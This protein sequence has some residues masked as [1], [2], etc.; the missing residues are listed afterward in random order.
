MPDKIDKLYEALKA[1]GAVSKSREN[2]RSYMLASGEQGYRNRKQLYDAL[3]ADG[4]VSSRNYEEFRDRLGL[5]AVKPQQPVAKPSST[6]QSVQQPQKPQPKPQKVKQQPKKAAWKPTWQ[7]KMGMQMQLDETMRQ[8]KQS[9]QNFNTRMEN[10][11]KGNTLGK[12]S[13]VK[14]NP[15]SGKMERRYY[16][17]HGDEV[18]TPL[19]QS[20][21]NL[22][23]RD[24]WEA[25]TEEGRRHREKRIQNDFE[26][27]VGASIDKYDP[28]N[29]AAMVW[30]QAEDKSNE[31]FGRYLDERSK[32]SWSNFLRGAADGM[33]VTGGLGAD[34]VDTGIKAFATHLKYHDLQRM[35]DDA[36]NMLGKKKQQSIIEDMYGALKNRYPQATEQQL[37]QAATEMAREQSDRRMYELA[38]AKNA[39][40]DAAEYFIRKVAAGNAMGTL[41][42]AAARAQAGTTGDREAR[43]DAE[44][45]FEKKGHKVAGIAGTVTGFALDPLTWASAGAGG[46]AVKGTTWLGDKMIGEAAMRKF[47]TT[48]G[49]RMLGGAIGGAVNFGTYEA[50]S[51]ALDQMKWG[52][53]IDKE[54]GERKDGF[55][56]GNVAGRAGHGLMM[57]AVTG[58]IA[59][60]LGNVSDKLVRATESTVGK[61]GIRAGELGVGTVAEGTIFA[62]PEI[63]DTYGQYGDLINSLS[64]ESSP[65]Y[66]ADEQERAAKIEELRNS[67]GDALMDVW[68][69]NMAMIA[70]FKAQH[71]LKSA[72]R[73]IYDLAR[74]K[75]GKVG[76]ETRLRSILDGRGDLALTEDEKKELERRGYGDLKDLTEEY[77]RY[78][79]AKEEYDKARP[80]TTDA[81]RMI[82]GG[83]GQAEL[84]YN[85]FVELMTDNSVSEAARAKMYYYL[86]GHG[87]PMSTVMGSSILEDKDADGN[88]TGYTVQSFGANGVI[89]SRSFGDKKRAD[90]EA[91]RIN[92]Q[93]ELNGFDVGERYYD[94]Q[95]DNKRMYEA[96][97]SVAEETG[98]PA[99]LLFDLMKRKTEAMNEVELEWAEKILNAY[100]GL[101][102]KY[103]SSEV[104]AA[105]NEE[106]GIDVDKAI[107]KERNRRSE[108][109]QKA[110]DEYANR[111]FADVKRKQEEAAERGEA[112][113]D[114]DATTSN[115][116][117]AALLGI[118]DGEQ[119]DPVSAAFNRGHEADAQERQD[120]AIELAD[121]NNAEAQ[122]AWNGVVQRINEDAAY[123]VAQQR[124]QTKQMQHTDGS[125]RPAILK[126]KDSEGND[127]QVYIVDGNVQMMPDGSMVDKAS[128]D[129]IVVV[130]NPATGERKQID[131]SADTGISSLGEVTTAEQREADIERSRQEYVQAQIDEA[132]GTVR[133]VPGQQ[134]VLPTGE[135]AVVV[136][137]DADGENITVA[138]GD[139]TQATVQ[140]SELQ[141]IRDEKAAA[142]YRQRHGI[143]E[144]P[145]TQQ[146]EASTPA[147]PQADG[148]VAGAPADYTADM[149]L[150]IRD[151]DGSEKPAMVM[152]RV[153][154][155]NGSFVPDANGN[156]IEYFMDG[157]VKHDHE[158]KLVDKVVSHVA[159]Q[160]PEAAPVQEASAETPATVE[161]TPP[162]VEQ[163]AEVAQQPVQEPVQTVEPQPAQPAEAPAQ[164]TE[165][166]TAEP[167]PI[168]EDGEEDW[169]ATTPERA[170]AYI[171][172]EAGLSRSEGNEF[173][174]AQTQAAQSALVK[175]KSAQMPRVGTSIKKY[176]E[177]KAKRQEK[178]DEA[179]RVLDYWQQ[180]RNI[181]NDIQRVENER[182]AAE[183][184]VRHDEA[185]A[186]AQAEYEARKQAEAERKAVGNENPMP[187]ITEK[188]NN[189][190]KVDGHRD[191]IMLP[192]GT[193]LKGHYVLHESGA[194]SPSHNPE[195]WQKTDGFPMDANDNSVNDRDYERDHDAQEHTQSIAR[196]YDQRALQS[197]PVVSNDGVVLSGNGRTMAGELAARDNTD[198]AYVN[199]LKEYAPKFGFTAEQ[200]GAMQH[201]RVSFVPDEAMPYTAETFAKFNQQE[202]KSQNKTEQAVK[203]GKT[204]SDDSFKG[205]VRTINSYDTLGDF[206]S[207]A[208]AS[209]GA[210]YDLHSA[211]VVPQAQLA[212]MVDGVRG[213]EKLSAVGREFLENMLIGKAFESDPEVVRMLTAEPAMRQ[214][215]ITALGEI[216]DNIALGGD[217]SLQGELADAVKLCFDARQGGA[218]YGEIVSTY[219]RQGVLFADPDELQTVADF[220]NATMLMLADVLNDKRV[221]LLKTTLQ[222]YNNNARQSASGQTD[223]FAGGIQSREDILR[224]VITFINENYGKRKEIEAARAEAVE[225]RKA[226]SVQQDGTPPAVST[227]GEATAEP[228]AEP[229]PVEAEPVE[230]TEPVGAEPNAVQ[231]AL[232]AAEQETNT[233]PT[234]AQKEAGNYKKGHVKIDGYDVTIE[235]PKGSVRRGIDAS[236]KQWEQEMQNTYGY[237]RGTEGVDGDHIDVFFSEDPSQGDV[238]VVDQVNKDGSFDEHKVMYGFPD[239]ESA[240]KAYLSN[241]EDGWQGLGAITP[242]SKEEFKKWIDSSHRK[243]KPFA[244]YSSVKPLGDTQ[245]GE[246]PTA[247]YSIEPTTY[248]NKKGKTTPMHLVTFGRELSKDEIRAGKELAKESRGWW[249]RE[250]SGFMMRDEDSAKALAEALSN[251]EA[252]QDA[253]PLS[254][255]DVATVTDQADMKAVDETIKVEQEPQTTPQYDYDREDDVYDKTLTGLR[256]VLNDR[257]RGAIPNIKSIENVIRDLRKRAKTIED[258]MATAA[259]ETI[260]Q[261]FDAL[262]NLNGRR[263]AYEQF[264]VDIRKKMAETE[265]DDALAAH[266]VKL[267]D[268]I[269]YKG[270]E[271]TIHDADTKQ[272][273]LDTGMAPVLYEVTDW[274]NVELP[275]PVKE[276]HG[277][278]RVFSVKHNA[279]KDIFVAHHKDGTVEYTFTDGTKANADEVQ[280]ALPEPKKVNVESLMG[281]LNEKG[282]AKLSD[283]TE[284]QQQEES[285]EQPKQEEKKAKSKWVDDADAE[286]FEELRRRLRQKLGGQLNM[287]VDPE[288]F[289]LGVEMSY[290]MLKHGARKFAEFAKQMIEAL[291]ENV[292]PYLKSFYNGARDLP[293]MAE[294][295]KELTPYDDVRTFDVMNFDKE[296]AKDIVATA[297]HIV[298]E[299]AAERE[300]KEATDKLKQE[301]NEQRKETEQEVAANTEALAS[302]AA[303]VASEVESKLPSAR[304]EREVNDLAKS[305]DDAIDKVNDQLALLGYYEA[306][307][308]E[309]DF[310]EAY[311]YMR[312][313]EKK[314]VKNVTELFKTLTK[315]LGISDPVVYD[316]KGKKQKSVTANI[317]PAGGDLTMRFMLNRNKGVELYIDFMLEPDY[318]NNRDN[319]VLKG[320]MFRPERNLPN[321]GRDYLRSN[322]YF[323]V[324]VSV[325]QMLQGIRSVCQEWLPAEDYV[326]MAQRVAAENAGNQQEKPSKGRK[327]KKKSVS[328]R[329]QTI[330][331]LFSGLFGEED[332]NLKPTSNEQEVHLQPRTGTSEREGGHQRE[333]NEPLGKSE[334]NEDERPD[335]GRVAGRSGNDTKSD[336]A[337]GSRVSEPSDGKRNVKPAKPEPAP[338]A[339]S[340]RKN[341]HNNHAE[342][343]TDYAPKGTSARIEANI[344]AI[345]TMQ[346]LIESG[347]PAT[348]EDM[349]VLR[350][351]SG[352]GGLGAA[353]KEKV[354]SGDSGYN[355][356]LR[357]DYQPANPINERLRELLSPEAYEAANMSRNS[358]YYTPAPVIDAMWD[359]A[360]AM[361][362]RGGNVLEGSAGIGNI[363]GL[364]PTDMSERS[365]IHAVEID[366]TTGNILSLLYPDANVEV[367]GF[368]KTFVPNGSVDLAI[369]NVPFVTG[370]R[371]MDETGD[372]DLSRKFHDIHDFCIAKNV[373]KLKEGGVGIFITSSG[374]LDSP[375]SAK[376][377]TWLVNE[378][379][380][381]VVGA[382][383]MHNQTF[384]G[385]GAT[386]DIIVIRKRVNGRKSANAIDVSGTLPIRTVKYNT[387]ETK[388]GSS[389]VIVKDLALDVNKH[390]VEH[391]E[392][393]AGE[394]AFAFE[395]GDTYRATSKALYPSP[396]INQEQRL[397]EWAQQFKDMDWD[398][399]EERESQQVVYEDLGEDVKEGSM[400]LDSDGNLCLAQRG[401][402]VPIN[403]NANKVKG[404]TKAECFNAYKA[405]KDALADVLEY[406]TTHSDDSG[407]QQRLAKLNKVYDSFVKTYGHL[408]KNTSISFLRSDMDY[409]SIAALESVSETGDKS[410]KR[411]VTYGKTDIFSR[412]VVETESEPK[413]TTIKDGIIASIYLNGRVDVPYIAEQLNMS[414]S[415]VRQQIIESGLGFENPTTTEMEVSYEYLSGNVREKLRQAQE[416]NTDGRYDANIKALE[417]VIPMNIPA[418]LIEF[419][420]GS[421]WVEPKLYEDFVKE[422][423]G[424]DVKLTNAGGTWIMSE[425]YY[426][427]TEQNKAMGVISE[428]C[429]KTIYGHEL[430]KAAITCKSISVTKTISTGYGSSKT[431]E[432]IVDKEAT[433]ACANKIDEIRQDFKDWA[434]GKMQ[435]DPEM[436]ERMERVYNELFNNS[437]PKEIPDEFVP[438]HFGGAATVVNGKPFKLRPHQAKAVIRATTQP[439]MLAHEVGTGKTYTL[440]STAMEMR[441]LGT[442][443]KPMIVV[444]NATV[445][446]FVASAKALYPN[447][448]ILTLEDADRNAEGRRNFYAKIRYNDWDMIVVPQSVFE[449]IPDSEERQIRFV[450]DKVEEKMMV[451]EKMREAANDDR[452][453]VLRQAQ[454]ELD[455]LNDE[456]NDLKLALQERKAGGKTEK[457][458]KREAKTRQNAM[459]KA[460]EMLDRETDDVD[461]FDDMGIDALLIDEAHEYKH[462]G[463]ATAMQR[464]VKGVDPSYSKKSQGVYLKTQAV[465][466]S[467]NGKNVVFATGTPISNTAAEIWTF[468]RYLMPADTM[469]EYG[470]YYFDDFVRNFGNIQ[471]M[472]EFATNGKYKENNRFA[473]YVNLPEL[474]RIWAGVAD[475]VL[476]R[477]AG[478][479]SDKI[480]KMDGEKA[481]DIYLPQTKAL[482]GVMKFVKDQ[483][484]D[485]EK[486]SGKEKKEN[487]HIPLVMYGIA[488]AA[489][490]DAR[491]VL[492]DAADEPNS[493]TNEAVRQ[494]LRSLEDT[495]E[496]N[497]TVAIFADNYQNKATGFNLYEDIRKKLID[498]GVPEAQVVVMKSG[499]SIKKKLEIFDKVNRGEVRVIMG[500]TF[501]LGT[502]VNIQERLHTLIHVDAPNRP[503][504]Y[505]QRNGRILRQGNLHNEWGIP[506]RVLRFGVEDSLDVTAYQ[507]LKTKG[508]IAD[509]IMEGK[510]MMSN[511]MENRVLEEEQD[512]FGD[513]TAQLSG[514]QYA[515]LK[516]QVEKE[517]KKLEARKKQW[518]A[519]QTYVHNQKP[520]LKAL[521]KDSEERAKRNK[522]ALAKVEAAKN[523]GITIGK[524]KFPSLDAMG[525]Y[526][527]DY[528]SKQREQQEQVR[529]AS[530]YQAEAKSDLTVSVGGFDFHIHRVITK[531]QKQEKGQL[532]LSFFSKTQMTY[533]CPELGL[534][535]VPVDGQRL[536]SALEDILE[537]VM[538]GNDF[539]EKAEYAD[540]AAE[541]YKGELQ[542]VEARDGKPFEYADELKQAKEK[543]AEYEELMKAEMAEKEVKYAEMDAS[544]EAAKGVQ[545]SDEDSDDVTEDTAKYRIR[546]D[547]P[548]TKTGIGYKVFVLKDGKLYPPMVANPNGEATPVGVWLDADAAPV[549]GVTKTGRQQVKAGGKGTQGGS[550]KLAYRPGWH[551]GEIPYALQ[552][553]RMNPETGQRELFPANFVWAEVEYANDVDYQEEAMSYG[554]NASGKFQHSLAGLPRLPENG[555][556]RYRTNPD[557]NTDPWVITGAM[558]VNRILKPSEVD[559]MVEA[560]GREPQQRQAG[561]ITDEQVEAL[562]ANVKRTMQED[563]DMMRSAVQQMGEKLHT[564]INIIED[565][566]EI[567]HPNAA[568]QERRRKSKGWYD[569]ATGQV[570]IV[571]DNNRD[572]DDVKASVGHETI[573]HKGLREL[574]GE[575]NY[576]EFLDETYQHLRDDL[577]KGVDAA[578]GRAF[579][580]DTT[581]NGKRAKSY[582]Q[583][584]RTAVDELFGRMAEKPFEEFSEGERTLWQ[585]IKA[586][587]RRLLDKFL[588]SLKLPKWFE[589][590]DNELRYILWRSKERLERGKEHPIDLA[591]D[592]VKREELGLTDEARYKMGDA[593]ETF[594]ARQK[595]AVENKGTVMPGLNDAQVKVVGNIP[596]HSYT[597]NIVE[598]TSQAIEA[599]K[600]KYAPN[601]EPKTLH[602]NNFGVKFDYSISGNAIE[603]SLSPKHQ[604]KSVNKGVHLALAEHIDDVINESIE[605]EEHPDYI[606]D[607]KGNRG[608]EINDKALMHRFYGAV[609]ID[610]KPYRV[611]TLMREEKNPVVG[612]GIHA[613]EVQKI[614]VLD[615]E[616]PNTPN[617]VGSHPQPKVGSSYPLA[618]LLQKV[619]K[620]HDLGKNLLEQ[621]KLADESTDLY[622]DPEETEDIWNDQSLGLQERIT[623]AATRLANNHRDNKT[624]RNDAMRAIG[625]NLSDLRK[626]MSLQRTFDMTTVKRVADLARVLMNNG[627]LNGLTQ[628]EVKRLLAAVKNS[629]GHNDIEG[630]VQKVM[631]IMVDNQLKHAEDTLHELEAIRGSKVDARGVEVQGQLD[632]AGAHTMKVFKKTRGWEK[633]D[634]EEAISEAQQRM[635]S[636]DVA[637][638]DEAALE[639][640]GLQLAL[641]YA[642]NIKDS[643]VEERKLREEIKQAHDDA[644]ERDRAT[645]S[646][647]QYIASLQEAIRQNKI[648]RAQS[649]FDLVGRLSDSLRES[650][651]NAKDFKEAEKQRI[652]EIQ[653]NANSDMEGRPSDEHYKP[654]FADKF[655]NNSFVSF[656]FA[657]LA[658][659][660]QMLRM[661]GGKSA[662]GE[663]Y[664]Y[665]RFMRGWID[666][667]QQEIN[668][669]RDK[670]AILDA[671]A[672]ELFVG[673]VKTWGDLIRRVG[674]LPKGTVS[675]WNG[676]EMQERELTQGNL[677]YIYMV[678]KMLDGRMKLRKMGITE[679][680]VADIEEVLDPRLIELADWLQDEFL[681]QTRNEYNETHKRMFG[682]SM[683]AIEHYFPLKILA[684]ARADKPEDLDNPDKSDGIST[685]TGSIIKRR[686]NALA[687]DITGADA[688]SVILDHVAQM[689][690]W[691][692]FAEFNRD[693]NT[694]RTYK[695][696]RNQ[697]QNMTTIYGSGKE[698]WKKFNDVCQMA[699]GTYR[700][701]RTKLDEAAVNFAKG[702]TAAKVSFRMF[703]ALKQF[704]SMPAY[705]PEARTDY[706]LRNIAN[707]VGAWKWSMEHLPIFS[708]RWRSRMSGDPRLLKSDMDWKM[709]RTRLMQLASRAGM[710]PNA[711]VDALTVSIGAHS[712]YQTRLA[713]YLRD[714]Y[715]EADAEKKAVQDAEVLYN[716]TQQS[717]EGAFT[718]TMQVDRSWLSVLFTVFRNAS[719][720]YQRQLH[721][722]LRNF[723]HNLTPGGRAR[724]I[725]F[726]TKQLLRDKGIEPQTDGNWSDADWQREEQVAKRKF[727]RQLLKDTLRVATFG[728]I[729]QWAWNLGAY[730]PYLLFGDDED[731][732]QKMWDDVWAHT[733]FGSVEGLTGGDLMSQA[734]QM[735]LTG[736]G[737]PA[738]L[739][740]DMPLTSDIM[741]AFQKL[742]NGQHTEAFNDIVNI[743][744]Q[745]GIGVNP[746]SITDTVLAI[747]DACGDDPALAHE[748]IICVF[749]ILQVPQSQIDKMYFD[750]VGL[751]GANVSKYSI[752]DLVRRYAAF[753]IKRGRFSAPW[754]WNDTELEE[755]YMKK[756]EKIIR[757]RVSLFDGNKLQEKHNTE[758]IQMKKIVGKEAAKRLGG[759]DS[760]GSP[761]NEYGQVYLQMRDYIDLA[762]DVTLQAAL[763]KAKESGDADRAKDIESARRQITEV[764][765]DLTEVPYTLSDG[766]VVTAIDIMQELRDLRKS[767]MSELGI[768]TQQQPNR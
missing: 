126:E 553:N 71:L 346:R 488:K 45:R 196:Q 197:V 315:E 484:D 48:L 121:P 6:P 517:V 413:P 195:T 581:K 568:V 748:A 440:I 608:D 180:V 106:F 664:L 111:L 701:P 753:K 457:D 729:M 482:R 340:E 554:M 216:V 258:G 559:A 593:P 299:Q 587:V 666:A 470:I 670:Y 347:E 708:E 671:K 538:T 37:Q 133:F 104:R 614:E 354:S 768:T 267:G 330:P 323:P 401:K 353:F 115:S 93:A 70:G 683:A 333:Q 244:E 512:L 200:V 455:Q 210:V 204:V 575:E 295:E 564:D 464:G 342:R 102:D 250:K 92:R 212:E 139:G 294:Y 485:Y 35:A 91:N 332:S 459:V 760:Y 246:Q 752:E 589:L 247:G 335:T 318:E 255:E 438:E 445:G 507:R 726:M 82:E 283:H 754:S 221:T 645:D 687:L 499:M 349:S 710:S 389:E 292:R 229:A 199:Y 449:R 324:D 676:G 311:G 167:M 447:A 467:K 208:E 473:G 385:T 114:P 157:E 308:V 621:S 541:R 202:M 257:K 520:R 495:K 33:N 135:E 598:A 603:L 303:T 411:I 172:N 540:R 125:L 725:E 494:T 766:T 131:P 280:D 356:R 410:G 442:A 98:A 745:A 550:G 741:A 422:R 17:T 209:L 655:V 423:T 395:K 355:P 190:T 380:A 663:G 724:S 669:V 651:A 429:D 284:E 510:K 694:L 718:S 145:A 15:E 148:R 117:I 222:L 173:I 530:G 388:R 94:W 181:Q 492:E 327:S 647:R 312:N 147:Q 251:E 524:M 631:D 584:R 368:E 390:F 297:E 169:Q 602:Y 3:K 418:H 108:Q 136:A 674:K 159:P 686:R 642:E 551:L 566:N 310:N 478:G 110:V 578:A 306:E 612:N 341:T 96:C 226:E 600:A 235:N 616:T 727:R 441:R 571:L 384:G 118:D 27:R 14:F 358:A 253:Q 703:T 291:G 501:T 591:R 296:G 150:T 702:V 633:T 679:E 271:A 334:Q 428:K 286:R 569:T 516:N 650:I 47:G 230:A 51:E 161:T 452:D 168:G 734:G 260:P 426:T 90:V 350:K 328:L 219:A 527:K 50:G 184:A 580:D 615:E 618:N 287:G 508:A 97:E 63:I 728:Y 265:R 629:V 643:K 611:M 344:K 688:L 120:I 256:N 400:L 562:N 329:E 738:Y 432:T 735:M 684:N 610:G 205:I 25:T 590:G 60:Y 348:P 207:D 198:G 313:A 285:T 690:H 8:V 626:A 691:N 10:I 500:S 289:A 539:R 714:G 46:A 213:H 697:V 95:G 592:I 609:I 345:E 74:S 519:D 505:T 556:Y 493:K 77:S 274:E 36:W 742:G 304:S 191:E 42:Q 201:P 588:G 536:K 525:D 278:D 165:Q 52:G 238:F 466:E 547:E 298:R 300:A 641:E 450:E 392:D 80:T 660:D 393:M 685:A 639:Y 534:E 41:M 84:P 109:E 100:N 187:A 215:V 160:H 636:S 656:L 476:T 44:Q 288:A 680:N 577:K 461:N 263:K 463:F 320:I 458:E 66:I 49:G 649:Y 252:V 613:Y 309:S 149:E 700:P 321:G 446:Q 761:Q 175:A 715:S 23:Y 431:T 236:G 419:T 579:I 68:T 483:L 130:Y 179:Q 720:S 504:D 32:P 112:P 417:R 574:V 302:E 762:E 11:R 357:D 138:L 546:E 665:N 693:I 314:A 624:L 89:T 101:G 144:E 474:V 249:D 396:S 498:A 439:L 635:G 462:L 435:S 491:L 171:F 557:P 570:N 605:V 707:P 632:P 471:Q 217:W 363:I 469:R 402:A 325:P 732:K 245:L 228:S 279:N 427:N 582:E 638:A 763:K 721:D 526:I 477:E 277:G 206:Y 107:R 127:Q 713:Q 696:F 155:E 487:S 531:E 371:V 528:N 12:T 658:T 254:V 764:K 502:G 594:K 744:V 698:L 223:L 675:F 224:D 583:H 552:F 453:P 375:N 103:G 692:A 163:Q 273:T 134:L 585:K 506:V 704:L 317:A 88:V 55:S 497:G 99:N 61:M 620:A 87:L 743:V 113:V 443:R 733:A 178:I 31:E 705:I 248:T 214:T 16:T 367:K 158:D 480:P 188:W 270:K 545:L 723:K 183:D 454:R 437:V 67:R 73:V 543:L 558:K 151:E 361:G 239:I 156:I 424:L 211:G 4:A 364:M 699:A 619:E 486:M 739:S 421:S 565:V 751:S 231:T 1:D 370:L 596:R 627:Y 407:L 319:L 20:R 154:Y 560:A 394:M 657:P 548:P 448:K 234:E 13:E 5:H 266:G 405:I 29:A 414:D 668:G 272:V 316:T 409:P 430:I 261:A 176:N 79:E 607:E 737:N 730:L 532:S 416:N 637:V 496:Y 28:D 243:T 53:Y 586:T 399:A 625:G 719:M 425:P 203:L 189:A 382:F 622:R 290:L 39:P 65:N 225:R 275:K 412:R 146:P 166:P 24:E 659:F 481:Q 56:F 755:K 373:R 322:N 549:A 544:V 689:E 76:F 652:R 436:S 281:E 672:A 542:Q 518:E 339:E 667:R 383:R 597:G 177:A 58:V 514:S 595:R 653:H 490:V 186:E 69:D 747:M 54:T 523:D 140:R 397:S 408:N 376:L 681:V 475:T 185:V 572:I 749:R 83:D 153:R 227:D 750:E 75:N 282:E 522:E 567:T 472:L 711:F 237:I 406:Q 264:L 59:P 132:Q 7:E 513:I 765:K 193:P 119:G 465:L 434:R 170:H 162:P 716:Q 359:V 746:Q 391:P 128:S 57:G 21:L 262:A 717:S 326:A 489:A 64:D 606:K 403:V 468:M 756:G 18:T 85:R 242:V 661:F 19:E 220:N 740:K 378:G 352:W 360:R 141:R 78:A 81:S 515:L 415:D 192:D 336:T 644:S 673:K 640:T 555:S 420:L 379:G 654:T 369:T 576:D 331:D 479:V 381:D 372:K 2:F 122:E 695:R 758:D 276:Y 456:L 338:L 152:G 22:K 623:A 757:E 533:S 628:Q 259:G 503:M 129:N 634:I 105:I 40:K 759:T 682:A 86:T 509:S 116:Q 377:R 182:R 366:E 241:Y 537:N 307:P 232:A 351:F 731:E 433:M 62:V 174:A 573:A 34:N 143:T 709:W 337:G 604:A 240:R 398:K 218:K 451:L 386:S 268:K 365:N 511:S 648:E 736:E 662:N 444:Q 561:A 712:M 362:F 9:Q 233:E 722:A 563:R 460:Q 26:R 678:N 194:S 38:V 617:G 142:D 123:M 164:P 706:L 374:T 269:M 30:Q 343:G 293:E 601:G 305:I 124:E 521:I 301:R 599:A 767:L 630:D 137:T 72:P 646:Y 404:H 43:E 387:G 529:T 677:M 535:D